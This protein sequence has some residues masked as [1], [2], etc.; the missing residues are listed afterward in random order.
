MVNTFNI[1]SKLSSPSLP[2]DYKEPLLCFLLKFEFLPFKLKSLI[3]WELIYV[4]YRME[5]LLSSWAVN[6]PNST[7]AAVSPRWSAVQSLRICFLFIKVCMYSWTVHSAF[8][9]HCHLPVCLC[10]ISFC[11]NYCCFI[12]YLDGW[13]GCLALSPWAF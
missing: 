13:A 9:L 7:Y 6:Y 1:L 3:P 11:L 12:L 10:L 8:Q 2:W 5:I 4:W